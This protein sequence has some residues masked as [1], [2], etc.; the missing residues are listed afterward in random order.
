ME[1]I[2]VRLRAARL[3]WGL[4]LREVEERCNHLAQQWGE[5]SY[6]IS[7]SWLDRVEREGRRLSAVKLLVLAVVYSIPPRDL[8]GYCSPAIADYQTIEP[9]SRPNTTLLLTKGPLEEHARLWLPD[10]M[11]ADPVP[12]DTMLLQPEKHLPICYRRGI[13]GKRDKTLDPMLRPGSIVLINTQRRAIAHRRE[14]TNEF[15]RPIYF[16]FTHAGYVCGWCELDKHSEWLSLVPHS[17]SYVTGRRWKYRK[18]VEVIGR[19]A[20]ALM[21]LDDGRSHT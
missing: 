2:G 18:E 19:V 5:S 9:P 8:L 4:T 13:I 17:L 12:E 3:Q 20:I 6:R 7:A 16:L 15:D 1:E 14:W 11:M 10:T 21:R